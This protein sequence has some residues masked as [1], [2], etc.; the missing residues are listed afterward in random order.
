M[1][2]TYIT[3]SHDILPLPLAVDKN[4]EL[5]MHIITPDKAYIYLRAATKIDRQKW[6][7]ALASAKLED[8][9]I[10]APGRES[11]VYHVIIM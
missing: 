11:M 2:Y 6:V 7:V 5:R 3:L 10:D 9:R 4:D 1:V 8:S